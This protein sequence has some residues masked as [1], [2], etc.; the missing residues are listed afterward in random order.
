[1]PRLFLHVSAA[2]GSVPQRFFKTLIGSSMLLSLFLLASLT[3]CSASGP[4][5]ASQPANGSPIDPQAS[6]PTRALLEHLHQLKGE[7]FLFGHQDSLAYGVEWMEEPG[8]SD[9]KEVTGDYPALYGWDVGHLERGDSENLDGVDFESMQSWMREAYGRGGVV[10]ISWHMTHPGTGADSWDTQTGAEALLPGGEAHDAL[11]KA[12]DRFAEFVEGLAVTTAEGEAQPL[13]VIFRPWHEHNGDWFWW[14]R[15]ATA[16]EDY[17]AL[18]RFTVDYLREEKQLH[19]LLYAFSPD[20]SRLELSRFESQYLYAYPGDDYVDILGIDNYWDL[21]HEANEASAEQSAEDFQQ[22]LTRLAQLAADK[23]KLPAMTEG[24][25]DTLFQPDFFTQRLLPGLLANEW[26]RQ[27]AYVQVWRNANREKENRDHFY[28]PYGE[29][30]AAE[31]F[32][33]FYRHPAT[34]FEGDLP[35]LYQL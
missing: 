5:S 21:G 30:E 25:Q 6:K 2:Q 23:G 24:G 27:I 8:R 11:K 31:D 32:E 3:G 1:M 13:P 33:E 29:H 19:N 12:L 15:G 14:G 10:T 7:A 26:T 4:E 28:V 20:R 9:V 16:E 35:D 17:V 34:L 18:Y 22:S